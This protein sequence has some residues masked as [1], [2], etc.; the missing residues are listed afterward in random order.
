MSYH[1]IFYRVWSD[2][3][4]FIIIKYPQEDWRELY[5]IISEYCKSYFHEISTIQYFWVAL[6]VKPEITYKIQI[7]C[8]IVMVRSSLRARE[9]ALWDPWG[10]GTNCVRGKISREPEWAFWNLWKP[11]PQDLYWMTQHL[12]LRLQS[13]IV[14]LLL[15]HRCYSTCS[16]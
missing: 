8:W 12:L 7:H 10:T 14:I 13:I 5:Y 9:W 15:C 6:F 1:S 4:K 2:S 16:S 11:N 3:G